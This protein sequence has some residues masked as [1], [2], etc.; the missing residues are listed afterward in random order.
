MTAANVY[1][2]ALPRDFSAGVVVFLV[3]LPLC[4]G[5][6]L[7]SGAPLLSGL[8]AGIVGGLL[9]SWLSGSHT[10]VA[11]PAAG[12]TAVVAA[13]IEALG[14]FEAFLVAVVLAGVIQIVLG[15]IRAG[16][17]AVFFPS[18]VIKGLLAAIGIILILKQI[19]HLFGHDPDWLGDMSFRQPDGTNTFSE[20]FATVF[21][22][23]A[24]ATL[25][26][27][28]SL[29]LLI[30]WDRTPLKKS[31][32]PG[33]LVVVVVGVLM[34]LGL[35]GVGGGWVIGGSHLVQVPMSDSLGSFMAGLPTP[36]F[37]AF[38]QPVIVTS[39]ITVALVASLETLLNLEA[40]DKLDRQQRIS[41]P[42]RE[43]IA[44]GVG[45]MASG[46]AGGLPITS[47]I[48]RSSVGI[49]SGGQTRM[50]SFIHGILLASL[51]IA[52]PGLL[53]LIPLS[54][55]AAVL[56][57][58]GF[59]LA[60]PRLFQQM[61]SEGRSQFVPFFTTVA[62]IVLTDL[63]IGILIGMAVAVFFILQ[64]NLRRPLRKI[65]ERHVGGEVLRIELANQ[66]S[67]LNRASLLETLHALPRGSHVV[68]DARN[69]VY[70]DPDIY[71]LIRDFENEVAPA[72]GLDVSLLG[73]EHHYDFDDRITYVD[74]STREVQDSAS[75]EDVL[76][77]LKAGNERFVAGQQV[78][79]DPRRQIEST[80]EG[81][82]PLAVVLACMDSRI[83]TEMIFDL[84]LGDIFSVRVAGNIASEEAL[85]S[86]E[87]GCAV[88]GAKLLLVLG[89]T[90]CG[91]VTATVD[92]LAEGGDAMA[93]GDMENLATIT[94]P[95]ARSVEA[96][97]E[98]AED[99]HG[100]NADF[101]RRVTVLNVRHTMADIQARSA[102]LRKM[103]DQGRVALVGGI[104]DVASGEVEFLDARDV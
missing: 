8:V 68:L 81:Q 102:T 89:H 51:V 6:A 29:G 67:F 40:V 18:S 72:H 47:V 43:L 56:M 83:A 1:V 70:M 4:L 17:L 44:Q 38:T 94:G 64:G 76:Q 41:P 91:A 87:Y 59:K 98:T 37:A 77:L 3:A 32:L 26:G 71:D 97:R 96:E 92:L 16:A 61:W 86:M 88:A 12:L 93:P 60:A 21:D 69:T 79:R 27:L 2:K 80:S 33:P 31:P 84:G 73:F 42:N 53:N 100:R 10:S 35:E 7:A 85:G 25:V 99:R 36:D 9:V 66:L 46:L 39:A 101:V 14:S 28:V 11:G 75:P 54:C 103:V 20:L 48:V 5:I 30:A 24:G 63:L 34:A 52:M 78:S 58:T 22:V 55:L 90:R 104:Y 49:S 23:H 65:S 74:V 13:Q 50:T 82:F 45:N 62:A 57:V 15:A 19:P 95:I